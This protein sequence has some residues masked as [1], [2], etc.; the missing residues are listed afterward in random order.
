MGQI[1]ANYADP[2]FSRSNVHSVIALSSMLTPIFTAIPM[3][4]I[5]QFLRN[6]DKTALLPTMILF[7]FVVPIALGMVQCDTIK[8]AKYRYL[9][10]MLS[11]FGPLIVMLIYESLQ[12]KAVAKQVT[13]QL[14]KPLTY[15]EVF[16][17]VFI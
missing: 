16:A 1:V 15:V 11:Y 13:A 17:E 7:F 8:R 2:A 5:F 4:V 6:S 14:A 12:Y 3:T 10:W 9:L